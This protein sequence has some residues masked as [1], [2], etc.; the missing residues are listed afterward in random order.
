MVWAAIQ[1]VGLILMMLGGFAMNEV[2]HPIIALV[3]AGV[4]AAGLL[5]VPFNVVSG[6]K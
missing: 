6:S 5:L 4:A 1:W 2:P 3:P